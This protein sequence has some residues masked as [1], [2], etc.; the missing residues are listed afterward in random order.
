MDILNDYTKEEIIKAAHE[1]IDAPYVHVERAA[2]GGTPI[3]TVCLTPKEDW[4]HKIMQN[5]PSGYW[6]IDESG[7]V[8]NWGRFGARIQKQRKFK[9]KNLED[10]IIRINQYVLKMKNHFSVSQ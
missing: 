8:E 1:G 4:P 9:A 10:A 6:H 7:T 5:S 2:L 3:I